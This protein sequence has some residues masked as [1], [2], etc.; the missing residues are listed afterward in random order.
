M[1]SANL[2]R[3]RSKNLLIYASSE[4]D[5]D[6]LYATGFNCPD[7]FVFVCTT[8]GKRHVVMSDL[9]IDRAKAHSKAHRVHS[10]TAS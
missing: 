10:L 3:Q 7:P 1:P 9:E 6:M 5:A 4:A 8:H 2:S